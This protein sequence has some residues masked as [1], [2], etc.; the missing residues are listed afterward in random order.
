MRR[1]SLI[2][3]RS[4][5]CEQNS[6]LFFQPKPMTTVNTEIFKSA[7]L[8]RR[9]GAN[10]YD[11]ILLV[12]IL[13]VAGIPLVLIPE[14][15]REQIL[16]ESLIQLYLLLCCFSYFA[17]SWGR[18]GQTLGMRVWKIYLAPSDDRALGFRHHLVRFSIAILS[19]GLGHL[20]SLFNAEGLALQDRLSGA[21]LRYRAGPRP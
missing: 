7:S 16:V 14:V 12:G 10:F 4:D 8:L 5:D 17:W 3:D 18:G 15:T 21:R 11:A 1:K 13:F 19:L 9:L 6:C 20:Y 2:S